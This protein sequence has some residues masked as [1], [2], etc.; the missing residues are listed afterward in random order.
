MLRLFSRLL[1]LVVLLRQFIWRYAQ[2]HPLIAL[3]NIGSIGLGVAVYLSVQVAN[4]SAT[5]AFRA[6]IDLVSSR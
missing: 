2:L 1:D 4:H 3:L 6:G 5:R